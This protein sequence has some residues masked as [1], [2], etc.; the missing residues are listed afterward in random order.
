MNLRRIQYHCSCG[1]CDECTGGNAKSYFE[2][3]TQVPNIEQIVPIPGPAGEG[4]VLVAGK[5]SSAGV[6][7]A[8][9]T[10]EALDATAKANL[11]AADFDITAKSTTQN[12]VDTSDLNN[13]K[14]WTGLSKGFLNM[15]G[16]KILPARVKTGGTAGQVYTKS[17]GT[18]YDAAWVSPVNEIYNTTS[19]TSISIDSTISSLQAGTLTPLTF[20]VASGLAYKTGQQIW[21]IKYNG[22]VLSPSIYLNAVVLDYSGTDLEVAVSFAYGT[23]TPTKWYICLG[24]PVQFPY[25]DATTNNG[26]FLKNINGSLGFS[27]SAL[28]TGFTLPWHNPSLPD[29]FRYCD[30]VRFEKTEHPDLYQHLRPGGVVNKYAY[31]LDGITALGI[32]GCRTPGYNNGTIPYGVANSADLGVRYGANSYVLVGDNLPEVSPYGITDPGH[33]HPVPNVEDSDGVPNGTSI[34]GQNGG[35]N[36]NA[37]STSSSGTGGTGISISNNSGTG[38]T[39]IDMRQSSEGCFY[40]IKT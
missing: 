14:I 40:I 5:T 36:P 11:L 26:M 28:A 15:I 29:G 31:E 3:M 25:F 1:S 20:T 13:N 16:L 38:G 39:A 6:L 9:G 33:S 17:S 34:V 32:N 35:S 7:N 2:G 21:L 23:G 8:D 24:S 4:S 37:G 19:I 27:I 10:D 22:D 30:G 18:D 12:V